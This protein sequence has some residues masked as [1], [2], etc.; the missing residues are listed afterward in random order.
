MAFE[1]VS[2]LSCVAVIIIDGVVG[3]HVD[4]E[5]VVITKASLAL[6]PNR[7]Q[8]FR[9][10]GVVMQHSVDVFFIAFVQSKLFPSSGTRTKSEIPALLN[11]IYSCVQALDIG[12]IEW[13]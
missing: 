4:K 9:R 3:P 6:V 8:L 2:S 7:N 10:F 12:C 11:P 5:G 13:I 1:V